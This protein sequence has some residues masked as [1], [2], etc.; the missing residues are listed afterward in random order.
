MKEIP[1][2]V[3]TSH[4]GVFFGYVEDATLKET[5]TL[6]RARMC[7]YWPSEV[8]GVL[9]LATIGPISGSKIGPAVTSLTINNIDALM[10]MT[11][12]A[13]AQWESSPWK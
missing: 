13:V 4:R 7:V 8:K 11:P 3:T 10:E 9:G 6:K 2:V 12:K 5:M 1:V